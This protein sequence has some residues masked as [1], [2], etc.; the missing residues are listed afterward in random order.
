MKEEE[1]LTGLRHR[2][3]IAGPSPSK[4][5][6]L[7]NKWKSSLRLRH[8]AEFEFILDSGTERAWDL[9]NWTHMGPGLTAWGGRPGLYLA[10]TVN[11]YIRIRFKKGANWL[12]MITVDQ[13]LIQAKFSKNM[14]KE[15]VKHQK[16]W[17]KAVTVYTKQ[18]I[19]NLQW[20]KPAAW[21]DNFR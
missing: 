14:V 4:F 10:S 13:T 2:Y 11:T 18:C 19:S 21:P 5:M 17:L 16:T 20:S 9:A 12:R 3:N 6:T 1:L 7:W 8:G 15:G